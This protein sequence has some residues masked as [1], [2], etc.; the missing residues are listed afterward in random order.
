MKGVHDDVVEALAVGT[1]AAHAATTEQLR[2]ERTQ[3]LYFL[4]AA[5]RR[6]LPDSDW[7]GDDLVGDAQ[8]VGEFWAADADGRAEAEARLAASAPNRSTAA[9]EA[10][11]ARIVEVRRLDAAATP[12]PWRTAHHGTHEVEAHPNQLVGDFGTIGRA[13]ADAALCAS[14]RTTAPMLADDV[15][16]L[17]AL[18]ARAGSERSMLE[19]QLWQ[20]RETL[21]QSNRA[22]CADADRYN[23]EREQQARHL[24]RAQKAVL[25]EQGDPR[26]A[27]S[28]GWEP[29]HD[30]TTGRR[31]W[32][33][34]AVHAS[35]TAYGRRLFGV[36][37]PE[38]GRWSLNG[39][40]PG[41]GKAI[42]GHQDSYQWS[43]LDAMEDADAAYLKWVSAQ[44]L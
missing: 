5:G 40:E 23:D 20:V 21:R 39:T 34:S 4:H 1:A 10:I 9:P 24:A 32:R 27:A 13:A 38:A 37:R 18:L 17:T 16:R 30:A 28:E 15:E 44:G 19:Q 22:A 6:A 35:L 36:A 43:A 29:G 33:R 8:L 2:A 31:C 41:T 12:K 3:A 14:Y 11:D 7:R 26:G 42:H 25:A